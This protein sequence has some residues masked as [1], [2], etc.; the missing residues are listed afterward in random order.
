MGKQKLMFP[1]VVQ[2]LIDLLPDAD[3]NDW[4]PTIDQFL[5]NFAVYVTNRIT[6]PLP[7]HYSRDEVLD[8]MD[9]TYQPG[10]L[11]EM[12]AEQEEEEKHEGASDGE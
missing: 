10:A 11:A 1:N 4:R 6:T 3:Y 9:D 7:F 8:Q 2:E 12:E 5:K